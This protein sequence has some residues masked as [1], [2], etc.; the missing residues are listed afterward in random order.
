VRLAV[1]HAL[2]QFGESV[3]APLLL[4]ALD[5]Q[6]PA[7]RIAAAEGLGRLASGRMPLGLPK[8]TARLVVMLSDRN[9][10]V[11]LAAVRALGM[12]RDSAAAE[13]LTR[14]IRK[15]RSIPEASVLRALA[16]IGDPALGAVEALL[17]DDRPEL[18]TA[19]ISILDLIGS[20]RAVTRLADALPDWECGTRVAAALD[21]WRWKPQDD[22]QLVHFLIARRDNFGLFEKT[23]IAGPVLKSD[24]ESGDRQQVENAAIT[25]VALGVTEAVPRLIGILGQEGSELLASA[26]VNSGLDTLARAGRDWAARN[27]YVLVKSGDTTGV[28]WA[29]WR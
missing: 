16:R 25:S 21:H 13:P 19:G 20:G 23:A 26:Y 3:A 8:V 5:G 7:T 27:G 24:L 18:R 11:V 2:P 22:A 29:G 6:R 9:N 10:D 12:T 17:R 4:G 14:L 15:P 1:L 28:R